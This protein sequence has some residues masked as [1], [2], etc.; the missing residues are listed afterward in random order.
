M[1]FLCFIERWLEWVRENGEQAHVTTFEFPLDKHNKNAKSNQ[2]TYCIQ[3]HNSIRTHTH[4]YESQAFYLL[5]K[6]FMVELVNNG[7]FIF[8]K[9]LLLKFIDLSSRKKSLGM[10]MITSCIHHRH[11]TLLNQP[12]CFSIKKLPLQFFFS[13]SC[14]VL[15]LNWS[16]FLFRFYLNDFSKWLR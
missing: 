1:L 12:F 15:C 16:F 7:A 4:T 3:T 6:F 9:S 5:F 14:F 10:R 13:Y 2:N 11:T 8:A